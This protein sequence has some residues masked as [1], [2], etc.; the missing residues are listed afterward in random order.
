MRIKCKDRKRLIDAAMG[1]IQNDLCVKNAKIINVF[2]GEIAEGS[3]YV[4]DGF[5]TH[6]AYDAT[7]VMDAK[8]V[9]DATGKY[10][11]PG[12]IDS[13]VHI[14]SSMM[15]PYNFAKAVIPWGT[16]TVITDPHEIG[17]VL[18]K[19]GV[20]YMHDAGDDLPM[21]QFI[22]I[23]SS[24]PAVK[25]M[26]NANAT[27]YKEEI[28]ELAKLPRVIGL[29]EVMDYLAVINGEQWM[30]DVIE[31][32][33]DNGLYLQGHAPFLSGRALSAY[34]CGGPNT[35]HESRIQSEA[36]E[37]FR[38]GMRLDARDSSICKNVNDVLEG[39][40]N[41]RW[42]DNLSFCTDDREA[43]DILK[44]G[45]MN[46]VLNAAIKH[47]MEPLD[48]IKCATFN[49]AREANIDKLGAIAPG[50]VADMLL[51]DDY[52]FIN[53]TEV[54]YQGELVAKDHVLLREI[55]K[56]PYETEQINT[57][58][59]KDDLSAEDFTIKAPI[60][61]GT[62]KVNV[63]AFDD[64]YSSGT[65]L[66]VIDMK[67]QD[68][69]LVLE[70]DMMFVAV[71]N[72]HGLNNIA[73]HVVKG[74]GVKVGALGSTVSHDSHNLTIVYDK[75]ENALKVALNIK[76]ARGG[77]SAVIDQETLA[78]LSLPLAGLMSLKEAK[79]L[80]KEAELM[81]EANRKVGLDYMENPLLRI[82]TLALP[83]IPECK[84][85][86]M[87]LIDVNKKEFIPLF[88]K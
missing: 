35:D 79:D 73:L 76:E 49:A 68:N 72:R 47:G 82:V 17:N 44:V 51:L 75:P 13:H 24:V 27:F 42:F 66:E 53:P 21:R 56:G 43:D 9:Y 52:H 7:D 50:Y 55:N 32:A 80:S 88:A 38:M 28:A 69:K 59:L 18:G 70:D 63:M 65:H 16:T 36:Y 10:M 1:R 30:M 2:N 77:M 26:E 85:S 22:D 14:E 86:D 87:G 83:V 60:E 84:M 6:V 54:F 71:C 61:S 40:G 5:I 12:I 41:P 46:D 20:K 39:I 67:V 4:T 45:H 34:L 78:T 8:E 29:A 74:F 81:K 3:V 15:T 33:L 48:V 57:V 58:N 62:I 37:K 31:T 64:K 19:Q 25:G 11:M 23:P